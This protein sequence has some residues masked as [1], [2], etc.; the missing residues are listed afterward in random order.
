MEKLTTVAAAQPWLE[1]VE[2]AMRLVNESEKERK[3]VYLFTDLAQ[4]S[5]PAD[6]AA[7][8]K[9]RLQ[10]FADVAIYVID[11]GVLEPRNFTIGDLVFTSETVAKNAPVRIETE[12]ART[13]PGEERSVALYLVGENGELQ[14]RDERSFGWI[15]GQS[16]PADF[17]LSGLDLGAHQGVLEA[18]GGRCPAGR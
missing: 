1:V 17:E 14:K 5:W 15:G 10:E 7:H 8:F 6:A 9:S 13:G 3:E 11:V 2:S 16:L 12:L 4:S 18:R